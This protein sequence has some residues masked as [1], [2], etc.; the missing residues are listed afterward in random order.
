MSGLFE[1][2]RFAFAVVLAV[3]ALSA[4]AAA[5]VQTGSQD[6]PV[7][8]MGVDGG[9]E[10]LLLRTHE[11]FQH[12]IAK[13]KGI[14][15][16]AGFRVVEEGAV[17]SELGWRI[18]ERLSERD[19]IELVK[20]MNKS[21]D[22]THRVRALVVVSIHA[23]PE[24]VRSGD[25][26]ILDT[27][28]VRMG[29]RIYDV[30]SNRFV[31]IFDTPDTEH[32]ASPKCS[33]LDYEDCISHVV[34]RKTMDESV[35][36]LGEALAKG[37][38][39]HIRGA[40]TPYTVTFSYFDRLETTTIIAVMASEFPGYKD[41][42]VIG[43]DQ[44]VRKYAYFTTAESAKLEEWLTILLAEMK[45]NPDEV[46]V[47]VKDTDI[48]V[49]KLVRTEDRPRSRDEKAQAERLKV[50]VEFAVAEA[51]GG[52]SRAPGDAVN[53]MRKVADAILARLE[54]RVRESAKVFEHLPLMALEVD[55][56][57]VM[58][59]LRMP[60]VVSVRRDHPV[61]IIDQPGGEKTYGAP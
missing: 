10:T 47:A 7:V 22:A 28:T 17:A 27:L 57:A 37:L 34:D 51:P 55:A 5:L 21:R 33:K 26:P 42:R 30:P 12:V 20:D 2:G 53:G 32:R 18:E 19:L 44:G 13:I 60:E 50:I 52:V 46:R 38:A 58:Q 11:L 4:P 31:Y 49:E 1:H 36:T 54:A 9:R 8:V 3:L 14:M 43:T 41:H 48:T 45:F 59:L 6:V 61:T 29:G 25:V 24:T 15:D 23:A 39:D 56:P 40:A 35:K 16:R